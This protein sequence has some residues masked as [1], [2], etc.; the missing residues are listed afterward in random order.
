MQ[1]PST[2]KRICHQLLEEAQVV[3]IHAT[4]GL[5]F[6]NSNYHVQPLKQPEIVA[7]ALH[8]FSITRNSNRDISHSRVQKKKCINTPMHHCLFIWIHL[9]TCLINNF[10]FWKHEKKCNCKWTHQN[11]R[12][13]GISTWVETRNNGGTSLMSLWVSCISANCHLEFYSTVQTVSKRLVIKHNVSGL[14]LL[15]NF[16]SDRNQRTTCTPQ[17]HWSLLVP[18]HDVSSTIQET[19][20]WW[21]VG[22]KVNGGGQCIKEWKLVCPLKI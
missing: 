6:I 15:K 21:M 14:T 2:I 11:M 16:L 1:S 12:W 17:R 13:H 22:W 4:D 7:K 5:H 19:T 8:A 10:C 3:G 20:I 18:F 9:I